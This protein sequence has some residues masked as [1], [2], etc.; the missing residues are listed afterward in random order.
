[1]L[2]SKG[3]GQHFFGGRDIEAVLY[4]DGRHYDLCLMGQ[5]AEAERN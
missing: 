1:M 4:H 3:T 5:E 2:I